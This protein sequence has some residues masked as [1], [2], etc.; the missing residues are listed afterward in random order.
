MMGWQTMRAEPPREILPA[1]R[2]P[3]YRLDPGESRRFRT[4]MPGTLVQSKPLIAKEL[5]NGLPCP[6]MAGTRVGA[7]LHSSHDPRHR[8]T[9]QRL[10]LARPALR[11]RVLHRRD[12]HRDLLPAGVHR[13][14]AEG[15]QLSLLR[16]RR[17]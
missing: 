10:R 3:V 17:G 7:A 12:I 6:K 4:G 16:Q 5:T 11:R 9:L 13:A 15:R 8:G 1:I 14:H 2:P